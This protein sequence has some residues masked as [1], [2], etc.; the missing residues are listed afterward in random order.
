MYNI[1]AQYNDFF[2]KFYKD[3]ICNVGISIFLIGLFP[4]VCFAY[5]PPIGIPDPGDTWDGPTHPIDT[6]AP[7]T[8]DVCPSWPS[9]AATNCYYID[10]T[11]PNA[12]DTNN[13]RGY[14]D[15]PRLTIPE[16]PY[17]AGSY[18]EAHGG[19]YTK[20][21]I[22]LSFHG[23]PSQPCWFR[24]TPGN[25]PIFSK[26]FNIK[27]STYSFIEYLDFNGGDSTGTA[28]VTGESHN[29]SLRYCQF[30]NKQYVNHSSAIGV[31]PDLGKTISDIIVYSCNFKKLGDWQVAD[32]SD[33][34]FHGINPTMWGRDS[35]TEEKNIWILDN[36]FSE[37]SGNAV[38]VNAGNWTDSYKYLHHI[39]IGRN[40]A[41]KLR[42]AG[43][44]SKQAS[45][46]IM[47]ENTVYD[48][49][50]HGGAT[51]TCFGYQYRPNNVWIIDN[52]C[53]DV[54]IGIRC[55][56]DATGDPSNTA[57]IVG[58]KLY[59][60]YPADMNNYN[61]TDPWRSGV[62]ISLWTGGMHRWVVDNTMYDCYNG[63][64]AIQ[65]GGSSLELSGNIVSNAGPDGWDIYMFQNVS[66]DVTIHKTLV[67]NP[68][69]PARIRWGSHEYHSMTEFKDATG[70][71]PSCPLE[72]D[73]KFVDGPNHNLNLQSDSP[74]INA[75]NSPRDVYDLFESLYGINIRKDSNG[76]SR[77]QGSGW[78]MGAFEYEEGQSG[79]IGGG[80]SSGGTDGQNTL[81]PPASF[82]L[83]PAGQ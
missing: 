52:T 77:P 54:N 5:T 25:M 4:A 70:L 44:W 47:S 15:K 53:Y 59:H 71:C 81:Q 49:H 3:T 36:T 39:Y 27:D 18:V 58:N 55:S 64:N 7:N 46:V 65:S 37:I 23:T 66:Q 10:N 68:D 21:Y 41:T 40:T 79:S 12:T 34:D 8:A 83:V 19:P 30:R 51:G 28:S 43:F 75:N 50:P 2:S 13:D 14:P 6:Q 26:S 57:Y 29:I 35:T 38:Q 82:Q 16:S 17:P 31:V 20:Q 63:I 48:N 61:P 69:R 78:D 11:N 42:Q 74:A 60:I 33:P 32:G 1:I 24:G 56:D 62:G 73:P 45:D 67:Y 76:S 80:G 72:Q 22:T 9:S